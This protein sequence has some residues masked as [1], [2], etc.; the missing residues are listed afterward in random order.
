MPAFDV[1]APLMSLPMLLGTTLET[2]PAG[3]PYLSAEPGRVERWKARLDAIP[4]FKV[5]VA[6]QG[7]PYFSWDRWRSFPLEA[8]APLAAV[9]GVRLIS[10]QK[11]PGAEQLRGLKG[12]FAVEELEGL[13]AEGGAFLD[14]AAVMKCLD[15][16]VTA[17]TAAAH[18]AGALAV[19]AWVALSAVADWRWMTGRE[20]TPWYATLR[21][22]RQ[23]S[24]GEWGGVMRRMA[25]RLRRLAAKRSPAL[26]SAPVSPGELLDK[27]G[28]LELKARR[29][30]DPVKRTQAQAELE[31][32]K[33]ARD[34]DVQASEELTRLAAELKAVN[35]GLWE[36]EDALRRCERDGDFGPRFVELAR[37]VYRRNT[38]GRP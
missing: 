37:S 21:L 33:A 29:F 7:N 12:R 26:P 32:L 31:A 10:L 13:D 18:L 9:E 6:W 22:F 34:A 17:D 4:G 25:G 24:L 27:I 35:E 5:G 11:G 30:A 28:I 19:P 1:Q 14:T 2:V 36:V 16:V 23:R 8:L 3:A 38:S 20:D 15:L